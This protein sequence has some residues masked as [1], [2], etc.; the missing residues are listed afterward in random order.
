MLAGSIPALN[1]ELTL[2]TA[3]IAASF[4]MNSRSA[5]HKPLVTAATADK[6]I[7]DPIPKL[8]LCVYVR[9]KDRN[10]VQR[11]AE[12]NAYLPGLLSSIPLHSVN[13]GNFFAC[14]RKMRSLP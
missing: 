12:L 11:K 1:L 10:L 4:T 5:P 6:S 3:R 9:C 14:T 2:L 8:K 7:D 13:P